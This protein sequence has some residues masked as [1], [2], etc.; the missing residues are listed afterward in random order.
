MHFL[1]KH[2]THRQGE[3][4]NISFSSSDEE[5][6][7]DE[8]S[9][10]VGSSYEANMS[11]PNDK[12]SNQAT[13]AVDSSCADD[14]ALPDD[15]AS[16]HSNLAVVHSTQQLR[17]SKD[18]IEHVERT[19]NVFYHPTM[20]LQRE[21]NTIEHQSKKLR[22]P[23]VPISLTGPLNK[24]ACASVQIKSALKVNTTKNIAN[25]KQKRSQKF[26][27][28]CYYFSAI[29]IKTQHAKGRA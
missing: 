19:C 25:K 4:T 5:P 23:Y 2:I 11:F 13:V 14:M 6:P 7:I 21:K 12:A 29:S 26:T 20:Q 24:L 10:T 1:N 16:R 8:V 3:V 15:E 9:C 17:I 28:M 18:P 27:L 22:P